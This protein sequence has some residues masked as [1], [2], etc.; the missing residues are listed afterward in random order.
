[1]LAWVWN[2]K[3]NNLFRAGMNRWFRQEYFVEKN[4]DA[5]INKRSWITVKRKYL[6][7]VLMF[8]VKGLIRGA[9]IEVA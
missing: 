1:M 6:F 3:E 9:D 7:K 8:T 4:P 2:A 5:V